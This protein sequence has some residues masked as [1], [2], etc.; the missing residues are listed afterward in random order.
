MDERTH[1]SCASRCWAVILPRSFSRAICLS[2]ASLRSF[3]AF[4]TIFLIFSSC[5]SKMLHLVSAPRSWC[6][7][8]MKDMF[9]LDGG[10]TE[11]TYFKQCIITPR[12]AVKLK[13]K[14]HQ[15]RL[16]ESWESIK[17]RDCSVF[18]FLLPRTEGLNVS[19]KKELCRKQSWCKLWGWI[20]LIILHIITF[21]L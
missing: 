12:D 7:T 17:M 19:I 1:C 15:V 10:K 14:S 16:V 21:Y 11:E 9:R 8:S 3:S 2:K 20:I 18:L 5:R 4:C 13:L 6:S